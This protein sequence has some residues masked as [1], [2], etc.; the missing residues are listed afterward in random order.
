MADAG[1]AKSIERI[2]FRFAGKRG[3]GKIDASVAELQE[4]QSLVKKLPG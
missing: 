4:E 3:R 1:R 2:L